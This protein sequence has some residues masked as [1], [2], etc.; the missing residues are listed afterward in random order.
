MKQPFSV[1]SFM[2]Q[3]SRLAI[4]LSITKFYGQMTK[5]ESAMK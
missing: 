3:F 4:A 5:R 1:D 2:L